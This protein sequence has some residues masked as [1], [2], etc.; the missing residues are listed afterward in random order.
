[1]IRPIPLA[2]FIACSL[3]AS[4]LTQAAPTYHTVIAP[5]CLLSKAHLTV[6]PLAT[7]NQLNL[8]NVDDAGLAQLIQAKADHAHGICGGFKDVSA[9][10]AKAQAN[11]HQFLDAQTIA[12]TRATFNPPPIQY[13]REV[14]EA[15]NLLNPTNMWNDLTTLTQFRDRFANSQRGVNAAHWLENEINTAA[16]AANRNDVTVRMVQTGQRYIQPSV[17]VKIGNSDAPGIVIG[18]HFDTLLS[19]PNDPKPGADDN[20]SGTVTVLNVAKT[21]IASQWSFKKP[22]YIVFYSAEEEGLIGSGF[23]VEDFLAKNIPVDAVLQLDM[24]GFSKSN[25]PTLYLIQDHVNKPLTR[26]LRKLINHYVKKPIGTTQCGYAC[27]DHAS[28]DDAGIAAAFPFE[29]AFGN[30]NPDVHTKNDT[31]EKLSLDHITDF[32]KLGI[33]FGIE[34]AEPLRV[35]GKK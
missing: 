25:D 8:I 2:T 28:W 29:S 6:T 10:F 13:D 27:S 19:Y 24:T 30:D 35:D 5:T 12:P 23:V 33:A 18:G 26:F 16:T 7:Q 34:L 31:M 4:S 14:N 1:M 15:Y 21:L 3:L 22:I 9:S 11:P 17:V 32:A 20:G